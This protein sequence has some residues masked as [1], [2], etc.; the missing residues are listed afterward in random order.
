[1]EARPWKEKMRILRC[2]HWLRYLQV[3]RRSVVGKRRPC[4]WF[5]P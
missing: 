4:V 1:M 2:L 3:K 5:K